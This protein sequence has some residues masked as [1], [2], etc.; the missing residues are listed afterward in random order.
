MEYV[1]HHLAHAASAFYSSGY[2]E[3]AILV[4]DGNGEDAST[5]I[6]YGQNRK[7]RLDQKIG[8]S[9]SLGHFY[10]YA[11]QYIGLGSYDEGKLM[12][13]AAYGEPVHNLDLIRL[14]SMGYQ[15]DLIDVDH[16]PADQRFEALW[17]AWRS[18]FTKHFGPVNYPRYNWN[19]H[20]GGIRRDLDIALP[21]NYANL[22]ASVQQKLTETILHLAG[23]A[24]KRYGTR[25]LVLAG[26]VA[27][28][29]ST[30]GAL[31]S[32]G[33]VD[34]LYIVP[35]A[36]DAGGALCAAL[37]GVAQTGPLYHSQPPTSV[38]PLK[39][40]LLPNNFTD[41]G[42]ILLNQQILQSTQPD[43]SRLGM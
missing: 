19:R 41:M 15:I 11:T 20:C 1:D 23:L 18:W 27:L 17:R 2:E 22:A 8:I 34:E 35:L 14:D 3:A 33:V 42:S 10:K 26:G 39:M 21:E 30:N 16:L 13:L 43:S 32:K 9:H 38:P 36:N 31:L 28:N 40:T 5:S 25:R 24:V 29:C 6:G 37:H 7:I 12:G 4:I